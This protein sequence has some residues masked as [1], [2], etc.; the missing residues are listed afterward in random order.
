TATTEMILPILAAVA[1]ATGTHPLILM[2]PATMS[3]SCAF[4]MPVATPPNSIVFGSN[5]IS[6]PEMARAGI[7]LNLFGALVIA[8]VV[9]TLGL[10]VFDIDPTA[11]PAWA[12]SLAGDGGH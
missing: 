12:T 5:R 1:V 7:V 2:I 6:I 8:S 4:M 11:V 9:Y 3:A 10:V